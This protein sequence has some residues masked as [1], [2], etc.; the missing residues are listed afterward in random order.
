MTAKPTNLVFIFS[1]EHTRD[2]SGCYGHKVIRTPNIDRLA[3]RGTKFANAYTNCPICVP[4]RTSLQ[5]GTYVAQNRSWDN[6]HAYHGEIRSWGHRLREAGHKCLSIGKLHFRSSATDNGFDPEVIPLHIVEARGD[7]LG[8]IRRPLPAE[9]GHIKGLAHEL[10]PGESSYAG[11]DRKIAAASIE[12]LKTQ[13]PKETKPFVLF[14]AFVK[15]HFPLIA[16][17][18]FYDMYDPA[19]LNMP[20]LYAPEDRPNHPVVQTLRRTMN[21]DDFFDGPDHVKRAIANYYGMVSFLDDNIGQ[22]VQ[23]IDEAGLGANTRVIYTTDHGDNLGVRGMWGKSVHYEESNAIPM[24][25]AGPGIPAG[26]TVETPVSLVDMY[27]TILEC[28]GL[29]STRDEAHLP[30]KSLFSFLANEEPERPALSEYHAAG[31]ITAMYMLRKGRWKYTHYVGYRPELFDLKDDP[32]EVTDLGESAAHAQV[33]ATMERELRKI[34]D[35][36]AVCARAF[37]DQAATVA[38]N[39]GERAVR[40]RGDFGHSPVPGVTP[41]FN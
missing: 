30:G 32:G 19:K 17:Q 4:A 18:K 2:I 37:A 23:A 14:V 21:Y 13:A 29:P 24:I 39:G 25:M 3:A 6:A 36:E 41:K 1:D 22:V 27:Q 8:S 33:R 10:G 15:P 5:T 12:W 28:T 9:R 11:Y 40:K 20:R 38:A 16:P 31:S 7:L 35:P 26:H 34:L